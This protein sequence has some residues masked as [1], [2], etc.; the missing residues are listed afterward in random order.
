MSQDERDLVQRVSAMLVGELTQGG[1]R[2]LM[3]MRLDDLECEVFGLA[4]RV[5]RRVVSR[6]CR[7][8][9]TT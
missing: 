3:A 4:D 6:G 9:P 2:D 8:R 5:S 1:K 7:S